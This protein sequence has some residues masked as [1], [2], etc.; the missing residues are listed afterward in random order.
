VQRELDAPRLAGQQHHTLV[1]DGE[2][3]VRDRNCVFARRQINDLE[4]S[5]AVRRD[6]PR[7]PGRIAPD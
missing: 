4:S 1:G 6:L 7:E 5:V 2:T 3:S